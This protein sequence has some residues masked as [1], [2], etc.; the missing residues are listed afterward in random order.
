MFILLDCYLK[1]DK[2]GP[3]DGPLLNNIAVIYFEKGAYALSL[4]YVD[5]ALTAGFK[6]HPDFLNEV[7]KKIK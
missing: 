5:K 4:S 2:L 7:K 6:V 1:A 3:N